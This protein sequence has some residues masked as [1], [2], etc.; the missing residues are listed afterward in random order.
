MILLIIRIMWPGPVVG[1]LI[2]VSPWAPQAPEPCSGP[3]TL[4]SP[5][6]FIV[7]L[8]RPTRDLLIA[9]DFIAEP[10]FVGNI[11]DDLIKISD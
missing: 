9:W 5:V 3:N 10:V 7:I 8:L 1:A 4:V 2:F 11:L 6:Y